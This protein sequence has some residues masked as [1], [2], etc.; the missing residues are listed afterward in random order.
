MKRADSSPSEGE[1]VADMDSDAPQTVGEV[2]ALLH[3]ASGGDAAALDR[4]VALLYDELRWLAH[5]HLLREVDRTPLSTTELVH[6]ALLKLI[7][8]AQL[9]DRSRRYFLGSASRA[10]RQVLVGE[11]RRRKALKRSSGRTPVSAD[12]VASPDL[13]EESVDSI[14]AVHH[15]L[16]ELAQFDPRLERVVECR[17][18]GGLSVEETAHVLGTSERT[19]KRDWRKARAWL[20]HRLGRPVVAPPA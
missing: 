18:F 10:M 15:A 20:H 5:R 17:F 19:V 16:E 13:S 14:I 6:E 8:G 11:A 1:R 2:T 9:P 7:G 12:S 3:A 4:L